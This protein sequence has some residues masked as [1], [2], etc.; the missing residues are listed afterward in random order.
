[1][2]LRVKYVWN[3][4]AKSTYVNEFLSWKFIVHP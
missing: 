1:M 2:L 3:T 4:I